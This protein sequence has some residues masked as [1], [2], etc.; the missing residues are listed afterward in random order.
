MATVLQQKYDVDQL[1]S[2][3]ETDGI[4]VLKGLFPRSLIA[5]WAEAFTELFERRRGVPGGLA[6]L[7]Q[8]RYY[9]TLPWRS[10]FADTQIFGNP[11]ILDVLNRLLGKDYVMVQLATDT[12]FKGSDYQETHRDHNPLFGDP[13]VTPLYALCV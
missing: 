1:A 3:V 10:P 2:Q 11:V 13:F 8:H 6:P 4:C 7:E 9:M 12:P 5:Q